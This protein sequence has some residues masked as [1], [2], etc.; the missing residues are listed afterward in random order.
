ME[1]IENSGESNIAF[2]TQSRGWHCPCSLGSMCL[3]FG[4]CS[5]SSCLA[6]PFAFRANGMRM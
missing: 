5:F 2:D 3:L 4:T 1:S 6:L